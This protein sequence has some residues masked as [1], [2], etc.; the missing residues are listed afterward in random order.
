M[1]FQTNALGIF[2]KD[3]LYTWHIYLITTFGRPTF[4]SLG[5]KPDKDPNFPQNWRPIN[6]FSTKCKAFEKVILKIILRH[7][8]ERD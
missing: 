5:R 1:V 8:E 3:H 7:I 4:E 2:Q 6:R